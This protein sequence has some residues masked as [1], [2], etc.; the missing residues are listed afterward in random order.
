M[1]ASTSGGFASFNCTVTPDGTEKIQGGGAGAA[2]ALD[3]NNQSVTLMYTN[4]DKGWQKVSNN[5]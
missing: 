1:D 4:A 3:Q 5:Q 2:I